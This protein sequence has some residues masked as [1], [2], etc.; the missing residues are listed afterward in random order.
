M[1]NIVEAFLLSKTK[2]LKGLE[3][4]DRIMAHLMNRD[5]KMQIEELACETCLSYRQFERKCKERIGMP[6]KLF[7]RLIRFSKAY[8]MH[9]THPDLSWTTIAHANG[10]FDQ[11]HFVRDFK[12]FAGVAPTFIDEELARTT[13]RLQAPFPF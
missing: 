9:E 8:R 11:A 7:V 13:L 5:G 4:Y 2:K 1:K 3:N 12:E 10:Y 6:P